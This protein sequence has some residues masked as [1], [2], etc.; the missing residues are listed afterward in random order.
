MDDLPLTPEDWQLCVDCAHTGLLLDSARQYGLVTGGPVIDVDRA[1]QLLNAGRLR[2]YTPSK[3]AIE[4][5]LLLFDLHIEKQRL[6]KAK[7]PRADLIGLDVVV[8]L[9]R[10]QCGRLKGK[11]DSLRVLAWHATAETGLL[12]IIIE[13]LQQHGQS[14]YRVG[15]VT[16]LTMAH[17][18]ESLARREKEQANV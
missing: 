12:C 2:G 4:E 11:A 18:S 9:N 1:E 15:Q 6:Q 3:H 7:D 8:A 10:R 16:G 17:F 13:V 5:Q 14:R